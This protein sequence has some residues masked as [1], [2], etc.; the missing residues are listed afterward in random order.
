MDLLKKTINY[1]KDK[2]ISWKFILIPL[3]VLLVLLLVITRVE[4]SNNPVISIFR[5]IKNQTL[6]S[7][8]DTKIN[9][10]FDLD[11]LIV[12]VI[13][14][15]GDFIFLIVG[16]STILSI[17]VLVSYVNSLVLKDYILLFRNI[18]L[19]V[20]YNIL[21]F[22][23]NYRQAVP[24][25]IGV[26]VPFLY[27]YSDSSAS[28]IHIVDIITLL[29]IVLPLILYFKLRNN[30]PYLEW[31]LKKWL[32]KNVAITSI[33]FLL[34]FM[35][36]LDKSDFLSLTRLFIII[37][38]LICYIR[39]FGKLFLFLLS[40]EFTLALKQKEA[41]NEY[42]SYL[43]LEEIFNNKNKLEFLAQLNQAKKEKVFKS[44]YD[45]M[46]KRGEII[47]DR[48][49]ANL[50]ISLSYTLI[51]LFFI[52]Y[53]TKFA[54][55]DENKVS[56]MIIL[57]LSILLT[58]TLSRSYEIL[59]AF[60]NDALSSAPKQSLLDGNE[61]IKLILTSLFE[62]ITL[63]FGLKLFYLIFLNPESVQFSA[64]SFKKIL[65]Y[66]YDT[67]ASQIFNVSL[68]IEFGFF[69]A[70]V[71]IIQIT[72]SACLILLSLAVY[73]GNKENK[74]VYEM[75]KKNNLY[76]FSET[77]FI[78]T[79]NTI[80]TGPLK[81]DFLA[82]QE[83]WEED[84]IDTEL[85]E[86]IEFCYRELEQKEQREKEQIAYLLELFDKITRFKKFVRELKH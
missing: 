52:L 11:K 63:S 54:S 14:I 20:V 62:I 28:S 70:S 19:K 15:M 69:F 8:L 56:E 31:F 26:V 53:S 68:T 34:F 41:P 44:K 81:K 65:M 49:H 32:L 9:I 42:I 50:V 73:S 12:E 33:V 17:L 40:F 21:L 80:R 30:N 51:M 84:R 66:Y 16:Y 37:Y 58:R 24:V 60:M 29:F 55:G 39:I 79:N 1:L 46:V 47:K 45:K 7:I 85:F 59:Q 72:V 5:A 83:D 38:T 74:S 86:H 13:R 75:T 23:Q 77:I 3:F 36:T 2:W 78:H 61:R 82:F 25:S 18:Y 64:Y 71:H 27:I 22:V 6:Y 10:L 43:S 35:V 57:F 48:N 76:C 67:F 4:Y